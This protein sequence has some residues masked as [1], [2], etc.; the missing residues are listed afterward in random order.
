MKMSQEIYEN[1]FEKYKTIHREEINK[2]QTEHRK[3]YPMTIEELEKKRAYERTY[4]RTH[5][6]TRKLAKMVFR[7]KM[8]VKAIELLGGK[9]CQCEE[10]DIRCLQIDHVNSG[11][12]Q[13]RLRMGVYAYYKK[14]IEDTKNKT[15]EYQ[16]LCANCNFKKR[17]NKNRL[18]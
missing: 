3:I 7:R 17:D 9:C 6:E 14:I 18:I 15:G 12:R 8:R 4:Y 11:G 1:R 13:E 10:S 2:K 16:C 5:L